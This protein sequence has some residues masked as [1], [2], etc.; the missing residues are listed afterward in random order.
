MSFLG[1]GERRGKGWKKTSEGCVVV[2]GI[3]QKEGVVLPPSVSGDWVRLARSLRWKEA[4]RSSLHAVVITFS[5]SSWFRAQL[6][7]IVTLSSYL[8]CM[9]FE[10]GILLCA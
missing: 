8:A 5:R 1:P 3:L 6:W 7:N 10:I 2:R 4:W 9:G